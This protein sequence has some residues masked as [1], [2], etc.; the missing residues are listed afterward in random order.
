MAASKKIPLEKIVSL[1]DF[2]SNCHLVAE[3]L[4]CCN[5]S[6]F[7]RLKAAG[8]IP[9]RKKLDKIVVDGIPFTR[10][11]PDTYARATRTADRKISEK[12]RL[13]RL[14]ASKN[15]NIE[16]MHIHHKNRVKTDDAIENLQ[17]M[18]VN[19]HIRH[20]KVAQDGHVLS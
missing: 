7:R 20:H 18:T 12:K 13:H 6:V 17:P 8:L 1:Y 11:T 10:Q 14:I 9:D 3:E 15:G 4:G 16:G 5:S 2:L 19:E